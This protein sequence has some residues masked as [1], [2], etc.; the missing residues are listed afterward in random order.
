MGL[1]YS[2]TFFIIADEP[3]ISAWDAMKKSK[4]MMEGNKGQLFLLSLSFI[5][6]A[7]LAILTFGIGLLWLIPYMQVSIAKFYDEVKNEYNSQQTT[8]VD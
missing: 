7:L 3:E 2:M 4:A 8:L 5:G 6:W 1:A